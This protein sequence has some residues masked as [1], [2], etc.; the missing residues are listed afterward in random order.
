MS[1]KDGEGD[2]ATSSLKGAIKKVAKTDEEEKLELVGFMSSGLVVDASTQLGLRFQQK[3][4]EQRRKALIQ[5]ADYAN[6]RAEAYNALT[7]SVNDSYSAAAKKYTEAGMP[8]EMA[9]QFA[10]Q[11]ARNESAIQQQI[12]E[13]QFPSGA[14]LIELGQQ[15]AQYAGLGKAQAPRLRAPARRR[16]R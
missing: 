5:P 9:K 3:Q 1:G 6:E 11:A 12:F 10:L 7:K 15:T 4:Y 2:E 14:N 13:L 16:R 8:P